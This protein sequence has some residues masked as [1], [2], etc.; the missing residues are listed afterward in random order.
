MLEF[1]A[2][3][4][5]KTR[6]VARGSEP[7]PEL[8]PLEPALFAGFGASKSFGAGAIPGAGKLPDATFSS[9]WE[10]KNSFKLNLK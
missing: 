3:K 1:L 9:S 2:K 7:E 5:A 6:T 10:D 4:N 8:E